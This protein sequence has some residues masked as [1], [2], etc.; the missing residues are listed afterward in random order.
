[1]R[2]IPNGHLFGSSSGNSQPFWDP[3]IESRR[4]IISNGTQNVNILTYPIAPEFCKRAIAYLANDKRNDSPD[5]I[6]L[7]HIFLILV[8]I[9]KVLG[10]WEEVLYIVPP[11]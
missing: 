1:M 4:Q 3:Q 6:L 5:Q 9:S 8:M 11:I 10:G 7:N 2:S